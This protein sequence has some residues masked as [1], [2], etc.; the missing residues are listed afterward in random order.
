MADTVPAFDLTFPSR[1]TMSRRAWWEVSL[2]ELVASVAADLD[3]R[4]ETYPAQVARG[5]LTSADADHR[6]ATWRA[7]ADDLRRDE[8]RDRLSGR[9]DPAAPALTGTWADRVTELR[10]EL[11]TARDLLPQ[12]VASAANPMT[13]AT[14]IATLERLD[15]L[16][17][18]YWID[19]WGFSDA[20]PRDDHARAWWIARAEWQ[21]SGQ[22]SEWQAIGKLA[23]RYLAGTPDAGDPSR[24]LLLAHWTN[25][26]AEALLASA[27]EDPRDYLRRYNWTIQVDTWLLARASRRA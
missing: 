8:M 24:A 1:S 7:I 2:G 16:L 12:Q 18:R 3:R 25:Q 23:G 13:A 17:H 20:H 14:A 22:A 26:R 11:T 15:A 9:P 10:R 19:L 6:L 27:D 21:P 4:R 5:R